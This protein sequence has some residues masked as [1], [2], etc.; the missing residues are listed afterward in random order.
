M[1]Y[2]YHFRVLTLISTIAVLCLSV[3]PIIP[4]AKF[5]ETHEIDDYCWI[6][7]NPFYGPDG[8]IW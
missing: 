6:A 8:Y 7:S 3:T 1:K 2:R 5:C 4:Q